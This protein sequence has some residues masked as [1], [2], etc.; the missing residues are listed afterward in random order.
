MSRLLLIAPP[1]PQRR[2]YEE[3]PAYSGEPPAPQCAGTTGSDGGRQEVQ[4]LQ[5]YPRV[6]RS[7]LSPTLLD[8]RELFVGGIREN[9]EY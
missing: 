1:R 4:K 8:V 7:Q 6:P 3:E 5:L 9:H 2:S